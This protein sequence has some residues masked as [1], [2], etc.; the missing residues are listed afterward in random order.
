MPAEIY[1]PA[2]RLNIERHDLRLYFPG[3][4]LPQRHS[5]GACNGQVVA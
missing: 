5:D 4:A 1:E 2:E 3:S